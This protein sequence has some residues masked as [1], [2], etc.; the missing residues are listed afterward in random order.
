LLVVVVVE[1]IEAL[2]LVDLLELVAVVQVL[3]GQQL[4]LLEQQI[5]AAV[6][7]GQVSV[8]LLADH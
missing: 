2:V 6:V 4:H 1:Q 7:A 5:P 8:E 3:H